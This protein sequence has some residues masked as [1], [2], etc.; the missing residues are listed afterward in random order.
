M[1]IRRGTLAGALIDPRPRT[2]AR[3]SL[4]EFGHTRDPV[5]RQ[6]NGAGVE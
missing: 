4:A 1:I 2:S 6:L 3:M 5:R